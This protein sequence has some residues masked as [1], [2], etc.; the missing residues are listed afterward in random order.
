[1]VQ[2]VEIS[3]HKSS[4]TCRLQHAFPVNEQDSESLRIA[5]LTGAHP[6]LFGLDNGL[7]IKLLLRVSSSIKSENYMNLNF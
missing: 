1:M 6:N 2:T 3:G 4:S 7:E 5:C